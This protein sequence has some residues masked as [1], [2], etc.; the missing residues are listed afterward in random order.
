MDSVGLALEADQL[1]AVSVIQP[2]ENRFAETE[3][4]G[5]GD[6]SRSDG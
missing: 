6:G 3:T 4:L 5:P 2:R 1:G